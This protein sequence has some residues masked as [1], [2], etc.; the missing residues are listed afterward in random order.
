MPPAAISV[1]VDGHVLEVTAVLP[2]SSRSPKTSSDSE[3]RVTGSVA[4]LT[5]LTEKVTVP[6]GSDTHDDET[7][8][9]TLIEGGTSTAV[10][11]SSVSSPG[12]PSGVSEDTVAVLVMTA[13]T[14][15]STSTARSNDVDVTP[16]S[17]SEQVIVPAGASAQEGSLAAETKVTPAGRVSTTTTPAASSGPALVTVIV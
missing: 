9:T 6:P 14:D 5:T 13:S 8:L 10:S 12:S 11:S 17:P 2:R 4:P 3:V 1:D 15:A 16:R 7:S